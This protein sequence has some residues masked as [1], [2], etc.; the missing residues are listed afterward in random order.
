MKQKSYKDGFEKRRLVALVAGVLLFIGVFSFLYWFI[1]FPLVWSALPSQGWLSFWFNIYSGVAFLVWASVVLLA[2]LLLWHHRGKIV[3]IQ[4]DPTSAGAPSWEAGGPEYPT[5]LTLIQPDDVSG[6]AQQVLVGPRKSPSKEV[7]VSSDNIS[8]SLDDDHSSQDNSSTQSLQTVIPNMQHKEESNPVDITRKVIPAKNNTKKKISCTESESSIDVTPVVSPRSTDNVT[9]NLEKSGVMLRKKPNLKLVIAKEDDD[10]VPAPLSPREL[11]FK[12]LLLK[13]EESRARAR[14]Q[15]VRLVPMQ[16]ADIRKSMPASTSR[17]RSLSP[18]DH[19]A[20]IVA[21]S[22]KSAEL[23][24]ARQ[25]NSSEEYFIAQV[26]PSET[27]TSEMLVFVSDDSSSAKSPAV[28]WKLVSGCDE[29]CSPRSP[30]AGAVDSFID[31]ERNHTRESEGRA[32][33]DSVF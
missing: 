26:T 15:E 28:Q 31:S 1:A 21:H 5:K 30:R 19:T 13:A 17:D 10:S 33:S 8:K 2:L 4:P 18:V 32:V 9:L 16:K 11:F 20:R 25:R 23:G 14:S 6:K 22:P 24:V 12:D 3:P 7:S 27:K 29:S